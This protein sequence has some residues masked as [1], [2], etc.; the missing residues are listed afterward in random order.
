MLLPVAAVAAVVVSDLSYLFFSTF[1]YLFIA[2]SSFLR[3][4][5]VIYIQK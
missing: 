4:M 1:I 2:I 5:L 3:V